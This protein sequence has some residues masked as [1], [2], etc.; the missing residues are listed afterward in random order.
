MLTNLGND[1]HTQYS[2]VSGTRQ[3]TGNVRIDG[4]PTSGIDRILTIDSGSN[5]EALIDLRN[6][7]N[8]SARLDASRV[9][10]EFR[11]IRQNATPALV[12]EALGSKFSTT[13]L[14]LDGDG[15]LG[16]N[17]TN[18]LG[19]LDV[20]GVFGI[21]ANAIIR[22]DMTLT[23]SG[24]NAI[25][26]NS[27]NS[28]EARMELQAASSTAWTVAKKAD[29]NFAV[30]GNDSNNE[31]LVIEDGAATDSVIVKS[32]GSVGIGINIPAAKLDVNGL[33]KSTGLQ[34]VGNADVGG[35][36]TAAGE[37]QAN[38]V[39]A[40]SQLELPTG[41]VTDNGANT[42]NIFQ[43]VVPTGSLF[44]FAGPSTPAGYLQASGQAVSRVTYADLFAEIGTTYGIGDGATTFNVPNMD[45][46]AAVGQQGADPDFGTL[47][48]TG[49]SKTHTLTE[50][51]MPAHKH[52]GFGEAFGGFSL[53]NIAPGGAKDG[54]NGG[55]DFDNF[56][57]GTTTV[58]G[59]EVLGSAAAPH[60]GN[61]HNNIQP[62]I[63]VRWLI[64]T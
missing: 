4:N 29:G 5:A 62:Y 54:S 8:L 33:I 44:P 25:I 21:K 51:E 59:G 16:I 20:A 15:D 64:K 26:V 30:R 31:P 13:Q 9:T 46:R 23:Y 17:T 12:I 27:S 63:A 57:Y 58:G 11:I 35:N 36:V 37:V 43:A 45:G 42:I 1:D 38:T 34:C 41:T 50:A 24:N 52:Y 32:W 18:P 56:Y 49:G 3:F 28:N 53:G 2:L 10:D 61:P 6:G 48:Q 39:Q 40:N 19:E 55:L 60:D 7:G 47:G 14:Y 22:G